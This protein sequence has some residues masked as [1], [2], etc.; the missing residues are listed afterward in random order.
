VIVDDPAWSAIVAAALPY[1]PGDRARPLL[2]DLLT[3]YPGLLRNADAYRLERARMYRMLDKIEALIPELA[4]YFWELAQGPEINLF[5][6]AREPDI[7]PTG[8][9]LQA[10]WAYEDRARDRLA[11][12]EQLSLQ[13]EGKRDPARHVW[14]YRGLLEIWTEHF[15]GELG[16]ST[17]EDSERSGPLIRFLQVTTALV[18]DPPPAAN[19][20]PDIIRR[21]IARRKGSTPVQGGIDQQ[22]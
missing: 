21:E 6:L 14:F 7:V 22:K 11:A 10:L 17:R 1:Q 19:T 2:E 9:L 8:R 12:L 15:G 13:Y 18:L 4:N 20:L 5:D 3:A 16:F